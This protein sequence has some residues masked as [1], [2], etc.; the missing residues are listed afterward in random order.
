MHSKPRNANTERGKK[1]GKMHRIGHAMR[2]GLVE[3]VSK[4]GISLRRHGATAR[5]TI[6]KKLPGRMEKDKKAFKIGQR[7]SLA[8][9]EQQLKVLHDS[10]PNDKDNEVA[11]EA[12]R[13]SQRTTKEMARAEQSFVAAPHTPL[14]F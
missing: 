1:R 6:L 14:R 7:K 3:G 4:T 8:A 12:I 11:R 10:V 9:L 13:I 5:S 2:T